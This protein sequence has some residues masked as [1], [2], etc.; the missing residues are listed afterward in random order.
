MKKVTIEDVMRW[1]PCARYTEERLLKLANGREALSALE[2]LDLN[3]P[4][5]DKLWAVL[6]EDLLPASLLHEFACMCAETALLKERK[7]GR[8]P[9]TRSWKAV[10]AKRKWLRGEITDKDLSEAYAAARSAAWV[11]AANIEARSAARATARA[12]VEAAMTAA[13][14]VKV[15]AADEQV[16]MLK[17]LIEAEGGGQDDRQD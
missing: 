7:A 5:E 6:R 8:E 13:W 9:D 11:A 4:S 15:A 3:I 10:E 16:Q 17:R 2:I 14:A 12:A 1:G